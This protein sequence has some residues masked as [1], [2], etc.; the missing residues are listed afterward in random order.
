ME[1]FK[2]GQSVRL[3]GQPNSPIM[4]IHK[5]HFHTNCFCVIFWKTDTN[6]FKDIDL[7]K[8]CLEL[9]SETELKE[10]MEKAS[11]A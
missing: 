9:V 4:T 7:N 10:I 8:E 5:E 11:K 6:C 1:K 3:K 2:I